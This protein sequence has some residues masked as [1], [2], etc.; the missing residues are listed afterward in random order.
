VSEPP[1]KVDWWDTILTIAVGSTLTYFFF[2]PIS[3]FVQSL[4]PW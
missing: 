2:T 1:V 3:E 4:L